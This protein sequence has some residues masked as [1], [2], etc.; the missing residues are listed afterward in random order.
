MS[1]KLTI[2]LLREIHVFCI[3]LALRTMSGSIYHTVI[4]GNIL[5]RVQVAYLTC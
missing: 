5:T 2:K 1:K 4:A 3:V